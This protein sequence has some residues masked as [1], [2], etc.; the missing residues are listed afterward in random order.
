MAGIEVGENMPV[1]VVRV[2]NRDLQFVAG[3]ITVFFHD[4]RVILVEDCF[5]EFTAVRFCD[6]DGPNF[7]EWNGLS[8]RCG[9]GSRGVKDER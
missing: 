8:V 1:F 5:A 6:F 7:H 3:L 4:K 9:G 2:V